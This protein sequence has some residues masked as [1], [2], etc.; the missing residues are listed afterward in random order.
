MSKVLI[1]GATGSLG[2][3]VTAQA[4]AADH[5]VSVLVRSP[6]KLTAEVRE[7]VVVH[8]ADLATTPAPALATI[9]E[10]QDAVIN[11][12]GLVTEGQRFVD[13]VA[14]VM[15]GLEFLPAKFRPVSWFLAGAALLD[16]D[17]RGRRG[18]DLPRVAA[19]YWPHRVNF[20][21]IRW[22]ALD[23]R[24]LCPGPMV[25]Q[26]PVGLDRMRVSLDR[27]P[28]H[29]PPSARLL[30]GALLLPFFVHGIPE[31]IV[32]YADAAALM[33]ANLTPSGEMSQRRVGLALPLGMR[34]KKAQWAATKPRA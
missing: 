29:I 13:L 9:F 7:Q 4:L 24:V 27:V 1:L 18:V 6:S 28:V 20:D 21:R 26:P 33:L 31:M 34:G 25:D 14:Q 23:W 5:E 8:Q 11:T 10:T 17:D 12:A 32:P 3:H 15:T 16:L 2:R 30:P 19:T 22:M